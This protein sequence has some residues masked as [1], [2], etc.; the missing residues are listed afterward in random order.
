MEGWRLMIHVDQLTRRYGSA[1]AVDGISFDVERGEVV[2]FLG[3]NGA[4]KTTTMRMLTGY[5]PATSGTASIAGKDIFKDSLEVRRQ[6]G[7]LPESAPLYVDLRVEEY[8]SY[9]ARIKGVPS[10]Q[11]RARVEEVI[12]RCDLTESRRKLI[13]ALSKGTR[14]RVGLADALINDPPVLILDEP[15]IGL[16]P[17]QIRQVRELIRD[18]GSERT[19]LL[20]THILPEVEMVCSRVLIIRRGRIAFQ[21]RMDEIA[22]PDAGV[23]IVA[24]V[25]GPEAEVRVAL[26]TLPGAHSIQ[27][28]ADGPFC[29]V[30]LAVDAGNDVREEL[31]RRAA[32]NG[33]PLRELR[34][35]QP[36]LEE[37]FVRLT[38]QEE[39]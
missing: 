13:A 9:R 10:R 39:S 28:W 30:E 33:W 29:R 15:T 7:Y 22:H 12:A 4:G 25:R 27:T 17:N 16:D 20:S 34:R 26:A 36:S 2:G 19:V 3:P 35:E 32:M 8:L 23:R 6:I 14:Q 38:T 24:E 18:L 5:L 31:S 37:I 21:G 1:V 11:V